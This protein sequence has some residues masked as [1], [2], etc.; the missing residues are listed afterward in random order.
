M[1]VPERAKLEAALART[2]AGAL[3]KIYQRLLEQLGD[4]PD[5]RNLSPDFW[6]LANDDLGRVLEPELQALYQSQA[7]VLAESLPIGV[8]W[9]L[10]NEAAVKWARNYTFKLVNQIN[11]NTLKVLQSA[12]ADAYER[13]LTLGEV[14]ARISPSFGPNRAEMIAVTELTRASVEGERELQRQLAATTG[15]NM[16]PWWQTANDE[17]ALSCV[18]CGPRHNTPITDEL[19]PPAHV[20]CRCWIGYKLPETF[21]V[22]RERWENG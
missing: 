3:R 11:V 21:T 8:D 10:V 20:R 9:A 16:Q 7:L 15:V 2:L 19:Y 17:I 4:P 13:G 5:W 14:M 1:D 6:D 12:I 18:I 22:A